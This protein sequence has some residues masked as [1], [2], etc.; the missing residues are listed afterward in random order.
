VNPYFKRIINVFKQMNYSAYESEDFRK[1]E[2]ELEII[3][4][5]RKAA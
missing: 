3:I 4:N 2:A 1:Y 5:E